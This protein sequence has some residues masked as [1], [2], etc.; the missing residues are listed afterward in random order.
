MPETPVRS[1]DDVRRR[2]AAADLLPA[3]LPKG[4]TLIVSPGAERGNARFAW[5]LR[6]RLQA[7]TGI[8]LSHAR[9]EAEPPRRHRL[10]GREG[11]PELSYYA[12]GDP[13]G[14]R[15][16]F[17]HGTP[18]EAS[19][20]DPFLRNVPVG[21][22]RLAVDRPGFGR[23]GPG[24]PVVALAEQAR[25]I[26]ALLETGPAPAIIVGSSYG[27]PVALQLAASHPEVVSGVLLVGS[28][29]DPAR[30][31]I[32][33]LQRLAATR[34]FARLLPRALAHS[35]AELL[36]LRREL[37]ALADRLGRIR[38]PVTILQGL[39]DT[40]VPAENATYLACRLVRTVRRRVI[41]VER[42]GHFLHILSSS[43]VEGALA[44][45]LADPD[46][47][48]RASGNPVQQQL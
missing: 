25:A 39:H 35:N 23:S 38:A 26:A 30:E 12:A 46:L 18:G 8:G 31:K 41:L 1:E 16:L 48:G 4:D 22:H 45:L 29:A 32:H 28:A 37:E 13:A 42:A 5:A 11:L 24:R 2:A 36:A 14:R 47:Q 3:G 9:S 43:L 21:Q 15:I 6:E 44:H 20:W 40:L 27:G 10:P 7:I 19:D 33:P 17:I 34:A